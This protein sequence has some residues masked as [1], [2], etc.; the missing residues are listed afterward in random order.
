MVN[1]RVGA[2][3]RIDIFAC[4]SF[5]FPRGSELAA[6]RCARFPCLCVFLSALFLLS[7]PP[8]LRRLASA[9]P[10]ASSCLDAGIRM[11][12]C[13]VVLWRRAIT[14]PAGSWYRVRFSAARTC[15]HRT[16]LRVLVPVLAAPA[17]CCRCSL[18]WLVSLFVLGFVLSLPVL[19]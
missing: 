7:I 9:Y 2:M 5:S 18:C 14:L 8:F 12:I 19:H 6:V 10:Y 13:L 17:A 4:V 15:T 1:A 11:C 16:Y 3:A